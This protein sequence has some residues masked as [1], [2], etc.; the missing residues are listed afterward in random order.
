MA[1]DV[2][3]QILIKRTPE[4]VAALMF[5]P[6]RDRLWIRGLNEVY[7]MESGLYKKGAKVERVGTFLGKYFSAKMLVTKFEANKFVQIYADE[8]FEMSIRYSLTE[9]DDG[10][11]VKLTIVSIAEIPFK[12]P[13]SVLSKKVRETIEKDL[14]RLKKRLEEV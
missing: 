3:A 9:T 7:P 11:S 4:E 1:V 2:N 13:I 12:T 10:T 8:P 6:K 14:E 5:N